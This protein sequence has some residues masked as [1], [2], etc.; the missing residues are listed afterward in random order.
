VLGAPHDPDGGTG[1][2][3]SKRKHLNTSVALEGG[4]RD[5]SVLDGVGGTGTDRDG[6]DHF[7]DGTENHS[8]A[9][10]DRARRDR[11]SPRVGDI[12]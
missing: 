5:D 2:S 9:I 11:G 3:A 12:V 10:G 8:L 7:E 4:A 1:K 6:A